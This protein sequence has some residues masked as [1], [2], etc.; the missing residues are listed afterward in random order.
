MENQNIGHNKTR[1]KNMNQIQKKNKNQIQ[2]QT[3]TGIMTEWV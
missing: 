3:Q 1:Y 2:G